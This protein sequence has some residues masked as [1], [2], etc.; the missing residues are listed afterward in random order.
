[1]V[2]LPTH[3]IAHEYEEDV[4][5]D[6]R[7]FQCWRFVVF[8]GAVLLALLFSRPVTAQEWRWTKET[9]DISA[10]ATSLAVDS[11][12]NV[13]ISYGTD[14]EGLKYGFRPAGGESHW[15]TMKLGGG[16]N[17]TDIKVD[18][19]GNPQ[20]CVTYLS[21]PLRYLHF[22]GKVWHTDE[23]APDDR[24]GVEW[25]CSIG[26]SPDGT[27]SA[28]WYRIAPDN[29]AHMRYAVL[30]DGIWQMRTLD[31]EGQT[32]KFESMVV[33]PQGNPSI[34]YDAYVNGVLKMA[35][36]D[37]KDW[38]IHV[39]DS[40]GRSGSDYNLGM[41][42]HLALDSE[43]NA[44]ISY[45]TTSLLRY[46]SQEGQAWKIQDVA[47][48][49]PTGSAKDFRSFLTLDRDER[50]HISYEDSGA[51]KHAYWDGRAWLI[52]TI[53]PTGR[54]SSRFNSMAINRQK[55]ILYIAFQD[56]MDGSLQVAVGRQVSQSE[57]VAGDRNGKN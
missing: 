34:S 7:C 40:R 9:V 11:D 30:K 12:G 49:R 6:E 55:N 5:P 21:L 10:S 35:H 27:V 19:R 1:M 57:T 39:V 32:G 43:G 41:G 38:A 28:S 3:L 31:F 33:D 56:P 16:V 13:H 22:D 51:L 53:V 37:G 24:M 47:Q 18:Q 29:T 4:M 45:Y 15:F 8:M 25:A 52:R 20:I 23:I 2:Y 17:Y 54:S 46:A 48:V 42:N 14:G 36:W 26:I 44:H 50:P